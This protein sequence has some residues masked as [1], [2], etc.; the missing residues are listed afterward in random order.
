MGSVRTADPV[1]L[2]RRRRQMAARVVAGMGIFVVLAATL[3]SFDADGKTFVE[4]FPSNLLVVALMS[5]PLTVAGVFLAL[6]RPKAPEPGARRSAADP[7]PLPA[8]T[9]RVPAFARWLPLPFAAIAA[10]AGPVGLVA[11]FLGDDLGAKIFLSIWCA[12]AVFLLRTLL[13]RTPVAITHE[14][15]RLLLQPAWPGATPIEIP[16]SSVHAVRCQGGW[17]TVEH[18]GGSF[19]VGFDGPTLTAFVEDL[20]AYDPAILF[21]GKWPPR[22]SG[23]RKART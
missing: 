2:E 23:R 9:Y 1:E 3:P 11:A 17:P 8:R 20:R 15:S 5:T 12:G 18:D 7:G 13:F 6:Q 10:I 19:M 4:G 22:S 14:G 16:V 21:Y